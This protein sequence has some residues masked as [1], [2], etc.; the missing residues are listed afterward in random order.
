V[1]KAWTNAF[2]DAYSRECSYERI[3]VTFLFTGRDAAI[4][5]SNVKNRNHAVM[6]F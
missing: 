3:Q 2:T 6:S 4:I 5:M 1:T